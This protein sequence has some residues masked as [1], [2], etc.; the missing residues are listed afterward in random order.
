MA[1][2]IVET[3]APVATPAIE[4]T[5]V[6]PVVALEKTPVVPEPITVPLSRL[7]QEVAKR[8][9]L[10]REL[11][12]ERS[13]AVQPAQAVPT[14][15]E[16]SEPKMKDFGDESDHVAVKR[17][18]EAWVDHRAELKLENFKRE[19][20]RER[21]TQTDDQRRREAG[22]NL[23]SKLAEAATK[24]PDIYDSVEVFDSYRFHNEF[25]TVVAESEKSTA[26]IDFMAKNPSEAL[27]LR[28]LP[29]GRS[30]HELGRIEA[31]LTTGTSRPVSTTKTPPPP[32]PVGTEH[33]TTNIANMSQREYNLYMNEKLAKR[34]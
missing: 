25:S 5:P 34:R 15:S 11:E 3:P 24:T 23:Q 8:R 16:P 26:L 12:F 9:N 31:S 17:F 29:L 22:A 19:Q 32:T 21:Q 33:Q 14:P 6:A 27:R 18:N 2:A 30:L 13:R 4:V 7:N 10:E 28:N 1:D 20:A